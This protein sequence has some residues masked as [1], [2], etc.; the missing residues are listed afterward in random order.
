MA[1]MQDVN[2]LPSLDGWRALSI[3][4]VL[5][6]H[7]IYSDGFPKQ[8]IPIV[9]YFGAGRLGVQF[10]F[11]I[12]G[13]LIT[14]LLIR[15]QQKTNAVNLKSF[16]VRRILR[17]FP[18]YYIYLAVLA[19]MPLYH[20]SLEAWTANLTFT[21]NFWGSPYST[22]HFWSL[23]VEEQFYLL[24]PVT[25]AACLPNYR[26]ALIVL[27]APLIIA[28]TVRLLAY[29]WWFPPDLSAI[30][31][32]HSF[33]PCFDSLAYGCIAAILFGCYRPRVESFY[34]KY[35]VLARWCGVFFLLLPQVFSMFS[36]AHV[37][38]Q[39][40]ASL[41]DSM[42]AF[43]FALILLQSILLP[44]KGLYRTLNWRWVQHLGILSYS[45]YVWQQ[46]FSGNGQNVFGRGAWW[47]SFPIWIAVTFVVA[48]VS[49]YLFER[50]LLSL[51]QRF[52][53]A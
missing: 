2:K 51:R 48:H 9:A 24:W 36:F 38:D 17:I 26:R 43:G 37:P 11:V 49:Y 10:F 47:V 14:W 39:L 4:L 52:R 18:V 28:P 44:G 27:A 31:Q 42:Q 16:Y 33:F 45:I 19:A 46:M 13:F 22:D 50:P 32:S 12:S 34:A 3:A 1:K 15:E 40:N 23:A 6:E 8:L 20:Q 5:F 21:T 35:G 53:L 30:F 41:R 25:L 29:K 7:E